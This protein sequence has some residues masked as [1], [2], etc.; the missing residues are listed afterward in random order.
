MDPFSITVGAIGLAGAANK[1]TGSV[2]KRLKALRDAPEELQDLLAELS[3]FEHIL[4]AIQDASHP[5]E[6]TDSPFETLLDTAKDKILE[7]HRLIEYRLTK[8]GTSSEVDRSQWA[9]SQ[10]DVDRLRKQLT[11]LR[12]NLHVNLSINT[13]YVALSISHDPGAQDF[14]MLIACTLRKQYPRR[15]L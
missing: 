8:A 7:L 11:N 6:K 5:S 13:K 2:I 14:M 4:Q 15:H 9:G 3:Q 10:K 1:A 12:A